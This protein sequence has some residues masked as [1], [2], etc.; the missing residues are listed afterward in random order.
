MALDR[1]GQMGWARE[2]GIDVRYFVSGRESQRG[3]M[4]LVVSERPNG[5][6]EQVCVR[7]YPDPE[8]WMKF[9]RG[10]MGQELLR[11]ALEGDLRRDYVVVVSALGD[12]AYGVCR[13]VEADKNGIS[14]G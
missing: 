8:E 1:N 14:E 5:G 2:N 9:L 6:Q 13:L 3:V 12:A 4:R 10:E 7:K 11:F